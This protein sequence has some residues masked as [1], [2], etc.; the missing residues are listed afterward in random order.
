MK[1]SERWNNEQVAGSAFVTVG[2][3]V[4]QHCDCVQRFSTRHTIH[5]K[6]FTAIVFTHCFPRV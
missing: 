3:W 6:T 2:Y 5:V 1:S 4:Y